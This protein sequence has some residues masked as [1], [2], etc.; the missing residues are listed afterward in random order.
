MN[1]Q[2]IQSYKEIGPVGTERELMQGA[3]KI[4]DAQRKKE[5]NEKITMKGSMPYPMS[6]IGMN[7][8]IRKLNDNKVERQFLQMCEERNDKLQEL[9]EQ[10]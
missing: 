1:R 5:N 10:N 8:S 7:K 2:D 9:I 3:K 4:Y 6:S